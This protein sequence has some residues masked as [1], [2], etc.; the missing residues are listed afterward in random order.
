M[1]PTFIFYLVMCMMS[2]NFSIF[3]LLQIS[4]KQLN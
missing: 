2:N 3:F 1:A 4:N